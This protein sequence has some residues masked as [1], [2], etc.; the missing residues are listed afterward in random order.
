MRS[1]SKARFILSLLAIT[2]IAKGAAVDS[3]TL[4]SLGSNTTF[5]VAGAFP[6]DFP[7]TAFS[8]PNA[9][10][11][12]MFTV[13]TAPTSFAFQDPSGVFILDTSVSLNG[14]SY[15]NSEVAFFTS[16]LGGGVDVCVNEMCSPNPPISA[17]RFVVFTNPIEL[18]TGSLQ[19]PVFISGPVNVDQ[20]QT[21]IEAPAPEPA[22][23]GFILFG[24]S[25]LTAALGRKKRKHK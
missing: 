5:A 14:A 3:I 11:V 15:L 8:A 6:S 24:G 23:F 2:S 20:S 22:S 13:P 21:F 9:P 17:P 10:Y 19:T 4:T 25:I 1:L 16:A 12:L 18:F 7:D